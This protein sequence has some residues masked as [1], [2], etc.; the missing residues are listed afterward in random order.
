MVPPHHCRLS[1]K[2]YGVVMSHQSALVPTQLLWWGQCPRVCGVGLKEGHTFP[3]LRGVPYR[4]TVK[5]PQPA[6]SVH[7]LL[8]L[9]P[10]RGNP[11]HV[12]QVAPGLQGWGTL[13]ASFENSPRQSGAI[14]KM[15][16]A[17]PPPPLHCLQLPQEAAGGTGT[18]LHQQLSRSTGPQYAEQIHIRES[19]RPVCLHSASKAAL[20][21]EVA[22]HTKAQPMLSTKVR[23]VTPARSSLPDA[24]SLQGQSRRGPN[25]A[26]PGLPTALQE[27]RV[28]K[29]RP[30]PAASTDC[31]AACAAA[32]VACLGLAKKPLA[33]CL[34]PIVGC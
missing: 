30:H 32:W 19:L 2:L 10:L 31:T 27:D 24:C 4:S 22:K 11:K 26:K 18:R 1:Q 25:L 9:A 6:R 28:V 21:A 12:P 16:R 17:A 13:K 33:M 34:E 15:A 5:G 20:V 8:S 29:S 7:L 3:T 14:H 23:Q